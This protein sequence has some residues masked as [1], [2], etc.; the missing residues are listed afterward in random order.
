M[1]GTDGGGPEA[2]ALKTQVQ[3][4]QRHQ[5]G[6]LRHVPGLQHGEMRHTA[7][8]N[9]VTGLT[10]STDF[11]RAGGGG[12]APDPR[13]NGL[14]GSRVD[15]GQKPGERRRRRRRASTNWSV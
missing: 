15:L 3:Q 7:Q 2:G 5:E 4:V 10:D 8:R 9:T 12:V 13:H 6:V 14:D 1:L 11:G